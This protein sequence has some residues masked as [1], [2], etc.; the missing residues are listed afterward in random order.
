MK[1][2]KSILL[3]ISLT[4]LSCVA[5]FFWFFKKNSGTPQN[6]MQMPPLN[7]PVTKVQ[8]IDFYRYI[9]AVGQCSPTNSVDII[10]Q[11]GGKLVKVAFKTGGFVKK[12]DALFE[13]ESDVY[14]SA[15]K[16]AE[17]QLMSDK[18]ALQLSK[19]KL[20]RSE[21]LKSNDFVSQQEYDTYKASVEECEG[22]VSISTAAYELTQ[23]E[24]NRCK[25]FA[26]FDGYISCPLKDEG[27]IVR[28]GTDI[29]ASLKTVSPLYVDFYLPEKNMPA[30]FAFM[31]SG[32]NLVVDASLLDDLN[33]KKTGKVV[34]LDN[35]INKATGSFFVRAEFDNSDNS[36]WPGRSVEIKVHMDKISDAIMIPSS[37]IS[38]SE[39]GTYVFIVNNESKAEMK[40]VKTGQSLNNLTVI[41]SGL[42][43][44]ESIVSEGHPMLTQSAT[45]ANM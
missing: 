20:K 41:E 10:P 39:N 7:V 30:V 24:L 35:S 23:I 25:I 5:M 36:F 18:A 37:A 45:I 3:F 33:A 19:S 26:E 8:K 9:S 43:G 34:F 17:G 32:Q 2:A 22:R 40:F 6:A 42:S 44:D 12:G 27:N 1:N 28:A 38:L 21:T 29:L 13:I 16:Q 4:T 15:L 31:N 11:V 14:E